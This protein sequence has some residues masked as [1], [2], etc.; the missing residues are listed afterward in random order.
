M[1]NVKLFFMAL[2]LLVLVACQVAK[3]KNV[4]IMISDGAGY[5]HILATDY[6]QYGETG[7]QVYQ[8]FPV[9]QFMSTYSLNAKGYDPELAWKDTLYIDSIWTDSAASATALSTGH[10][11]KNGYLGMDAEKNN[12]L[13]FSEFIQSQGK[14]LG[15]VTTVVACHATPAGF[16]M[17]SPF[18]K[19]YP[20]IFKSM[21]LDSKLSVMMGAGLNDSGTLPD[22]KKYYYV[23]QK[24]FWQQVEKEVTEFDTNNDGEADKSIADLDGDNIPDAWSLIRER[25]EFTNIT[26]D[27]AP[28]RLLGIFQSRANAQYDRKGDKQAAPFQV[29][30]REEIPTL[31]EMTN[32]AI[33]ILD[34]KNGFWLMIEGGAIDKAAH[35]NWNG[36][37]IEEEIDFNHAVES[38]VKWIETNSSWKET[39]LIVTAD[40]ETGHISGEANMKNKVVADVKNKGIGQVPEFYFLSSEHTNSLVPF[41]AKGVGAEKFSEKA[42]NSDPVH[43][44]FMDSTDLAKTLFELYQD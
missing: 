18:R 39:L 23:G 30:L 15:T 36:R 9:N 40:H 37:V 28:K 7:K 19:D 38:V 11:T 31:E 26:K 1:K 29:P 21:I 13:H 14:K 25:Q 22:H 20:N 33:N 12:L 4:I 43:G 27:N 42:I 41:F 17:H 5:N 10:K 32:A 44:K 24:E 16:T 34:N 2:L 8:S 35:A 6:Y 3:P